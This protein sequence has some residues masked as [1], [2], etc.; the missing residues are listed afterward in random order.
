MKSG[1]N[2]NVAFINDDGELSGIREKQIIWE[3]GLLGEMILARL[4]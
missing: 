1:R 4:L 2:K 3:Y